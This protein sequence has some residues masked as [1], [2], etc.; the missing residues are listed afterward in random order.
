LDLIESKIEEMVDFLLKTFYRLNS[1]RR[2]N[3]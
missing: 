3:P 2:Q 1:D